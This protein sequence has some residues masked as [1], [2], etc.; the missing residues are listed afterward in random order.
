MFE[1]LIAVLA[2]LGGIL[3]AIL[4]YVE[5]LKIK[6]RKKEDTLEDRVDKLTS[7]LKEAT[8]LI[9]EVESEIRSRTALAEKLESDIKSYKELAE[10]KKQEI[11]TIVQFV[12]GELRTESR[13][14][15][16]AGFSINFLFFI[17]GVGATIAITLITK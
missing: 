11:E 6:K 10:I 4:Q 8:G 15:F 13:K 3:A 1:I 5:I 7:S 2:V 9:D 14:S 16:W 12:R 17:L